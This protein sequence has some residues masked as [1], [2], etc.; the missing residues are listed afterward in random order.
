MD[1]RRDPCARRQVSLG[2]PTSHSDVNIEPSVSEEHLEAMRFIPGLNY[3]LRWHVLHM[4]RATTEHTETLVLAL[5]PNNRCL[6]G[7]VANAVFPGG[8]CNLDACNKLELRNFNHPSRELSLL[9]SDNACGRSLTHLCL[10]CELRS[11][12]GP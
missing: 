9:V 1:A 8:S 12:Q 5:P 4:L 2:F 6:S 11:L 7:Q 10:E 3:T